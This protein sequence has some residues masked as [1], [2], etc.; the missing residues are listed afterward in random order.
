MISI[1]TGKGDTLRTAL[2][3]KNIFSSFLV[4]ILSVLISLMLVPLCI[5]F[6]NTAQYGIWLTLSSIIGWMSFF[7]IGFT[8][9]LRN[10][11]TE[12]LALGQIDKAKD[13]I[14]T[15]F[16]S[17]LG[18]FFLIWVIFLPA[19]YF[20][21]WYDILNIEVIEEPDLRMIIF[22]ILTFFCITFAFKVSNVV[23]L[24]MH[25]PGQSSAI[26][27]IGQLFSLMAIFILTRI[28]KGSLL[29]LSLSLTI[30]PF[31][32]VLGYYGYLFFYKYPELA[33][34]FACFK[35]SSLMGILGL[36]SK[37]FIIQI[38]AIVQ[39]Q[40]GNFLIAR[41]YSMAEVTN[42][43]IAFKYF[44][45]LNMIFTIILLPFWSAA[46]EAYTRKDFEWI[47]QMISQYQKMFVL[48][49]AGGVGMLFISDW[50]YKI[51][52][53]ESI[54]ISFNLSFWCFVSVM[55]SMFGGIY[56]SLL[57]GIG[58]VKLQF[59]CSLFSPI[60]YVLLVKIFHSYQFGVECVL[61]ASVL[62]NFYSFFLAPMQ[63]FRIFKSKKSYVCERK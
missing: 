60:L 59:Y 17:L 38:A 32:V 27:M 28:F 19:V 51:W 24:A 50:I 61:I 2:L 4:K 33:P 34:S 54:N 62:S 57:N 43:N 9:G 15:T 53:S 5:D 39:F 1:L 6:L 22:I 3:I 25:K 16:L 31:L 49:M 47:K 42:F 30:C 8:N 18:I 58:Q 7:D 40:T 48:F 10:K 21:D 37:F 11:L 29:Y 45:I 35:R 13:L 41:F 46:T 56:V 26:D 55:V 23:L 52:I 36:G 44:N 20:F 12:A 14:S 63:Y